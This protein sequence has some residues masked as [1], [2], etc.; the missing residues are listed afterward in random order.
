[1][2]LHLCM[3]L[4][5]LGNAQDEVKC[6]LGAKEAWPLD[7]IYQKMKKKD[8]SIGGTLNLPLRI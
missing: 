6:V 7:K 5:S 2:T 1:M 8:Y 4:L 3:E